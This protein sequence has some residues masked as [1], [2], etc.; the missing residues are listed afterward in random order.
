MTR[1]LFLALFSLIKDD[2][3]FFLS[4]LSLFVKD[5]KFLLML[6]FEVSESSVELV[7][8]DDEE[9]ELRKVSEGALLD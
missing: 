2:F 4:F 5:F 3:S 8:K 7:S 9:D 1:A 6:L